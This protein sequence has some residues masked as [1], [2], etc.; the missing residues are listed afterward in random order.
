MHELSEPW[1]LIGENHRRRAVILWHNRPALCKVVYGAI[2]LK[3]K[4]K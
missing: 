4:L 1:S 2:A 3:A